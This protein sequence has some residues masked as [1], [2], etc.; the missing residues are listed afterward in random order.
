MWISEYQEEL[1]LI[2][3]DGKT[4]LHSIIR[5]GLNSLGLTCKSV[6]KVQQEKYTPENMLYY[7]DFL[8]AMSDIDPRRIR[9][10][11]EAHLNQL[12]KV[13]NHN[14]LLLIYL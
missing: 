14:M 8:G 12:G 1:R 4:P 6:T 3:A 7:L 13:I 2:H 11:H 5:R 10:F 9:V